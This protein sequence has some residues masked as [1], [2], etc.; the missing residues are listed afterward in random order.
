MCALM[1]ILVLTLSACGGG[2]GSEAEEKLTEVRGNYLEMTA[3]SGH[4][5]L[6]ADYGRRVYTYG[7][8]FNWQREGETLLT[9]TAP[10]LVAGT[11]AHISAGETALEYDGT[12]LETGPL[13]PAGLSPVDA[14]PALFAYAREGFAAECAMEEAEG[15]AKK[16][17]V[18]CRDPESEPGAGREAELLFD[19]TTGALLGGELSQDGFTVIQCDISGFVMTLPPEQ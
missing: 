4:A 6:T 7:I 3:C 18:I 12:M 14:L 15:E 19:G 2:G 8:D 13:D 1:M 9:I 16:L 5:D 10:E 11:V 17:R